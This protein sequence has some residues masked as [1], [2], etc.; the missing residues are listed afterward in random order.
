MVKRLSPLISCVI[1]SKSI[2]H[3]VKLGR[4][5]SMYDLPISMQIVQCKEQMYQCQPQ[6]LL[7]QPILSYSFHHLDEVVPQRFVQYTSMFLTILF[8]LEI[9]E[10]LSH[11]LETGVFPLA[12]AEV[13]IDGDFIHVLF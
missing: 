8:Q 13:L 3:D 9:V 1:V 11:V 10:G 12:F 7:A 2:S 6:H 4:N 5:T